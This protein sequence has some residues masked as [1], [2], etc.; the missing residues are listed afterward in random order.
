[1]AEKKAYRIKRLSGFTGEAWL[2]RV[3]PPM[4]YGWEEEAWTE[5]VV[6]SSAIALFSGPETYLF[7]ADASGKVLD[8]GDL[9]GSYRGGLDC[10]QAI[11]NAG[12]MIV[13]Q[14]AN[15]EG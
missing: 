11:R 4:P 3:D 2:Y 7:P 12:Y 15:S 8:W 14:E 6:S 1:M 5:Y 9:E 10:D 13:E